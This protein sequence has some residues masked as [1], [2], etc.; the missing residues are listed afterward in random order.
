MS[1]KNNHTCA[2]IADFSPCRYDVL[3]IRNS[4]TKKSKNNQLPVDQVLESKSKRF[5]N[6]AKRG[7]FSLQPDRQ[8]KNN[9]SRKYQNYDQQNMEVKEKLYPVSFNYAWKTF[10]HQVQNMYATQNFQTFSSCSQAG[11]TFTVPSGP[12]TSRCFNGVHRNQ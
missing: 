8:M 12:P 6:T 2:N 5:G 11:E 3:E 7:S 1:S 4:P 9:L 10:E